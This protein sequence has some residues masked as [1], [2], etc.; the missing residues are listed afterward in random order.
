MFKTN[1]HLTADALGF[2]EYAEPSFDHVEL[3]STADLDEDDPVYHGRNVLWDL[4]Q[5]AYVVEVPVDKILVTEGNLWNFNHVAGLLE[6]INQGDAVLTPPAARIYRIDEET[7][8]DSQ[9]YDSEE[10]LLYD[11]GLSAPW[12]RSDAGTYYA[13]LVDG[14]H[15]AIAAIA[16]GERAIPVFVGDNYR[17]D[18][19]PE[20]WL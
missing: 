14:N 7:V 16:A 1:F 9:N 2:L 8:R 12:T 15:R 4:S 20:E 11:M 19:L 10:E 17:E 18:I 3:L 5:G 13:Q 6:Y